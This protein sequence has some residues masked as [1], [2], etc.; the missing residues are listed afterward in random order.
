MPRIDPQKLLNCLSVLLAPN[1]GIRGPNDV[2][3]LTGLMAKFSKKLVS[4]CIYIQILKCTETDLL[5]QFMSAGGWSLTHMWL[6]D[7]ILSKNWPLVQEILE[8]L[9]L[10]PVDVQRLKS[11]TAPKLVK[12]L[13]KEGGVEAV[14][15]LATKLVEQ[16][17][18]IVKGEPMTVESTAV[19][20]GNAPAIANAGPKPTDTEDTAAKAAPTDGGT[21]SDKPTNKVDDVDNKDKLDAKSASTNVVFLDAVP[22]DEQETNDD[23]VSDPLALPSDVEDGGTVAGSGS[24]TKSKPNNEGL[25]FKITVKD[26]K[27][28][29]AKVESSPRKAAPPAITSPSANK[30]AKVID[31]DTIDS[32]KVKDLPSNSSSSSGKEEKSDKSEKDI[33]K[34]RGSRDSSKSKSRDKDRERDKNRDRE[35]IK[36]RKGSDSSRSSDIKSSSSSSKHHSSSSSSHRSSSSHKSSSRSSR[37]HKDSKDRERDKDK[38]KSSSSSTKSSS[39]SSSRDKSSSSRDKDRDKDKDNVVTEPKISQADK[40]K[41][42]LSKVMSQSISKLGKIPKKIH[43]AESDSSKTSAESSSSKKPSISIEVRKDA[44]NRPKTV[45]TFNSQFRSHGLAEEAPPPPSRRGLKKPSSTSAPGTAIPTTVGS[46]RLSVSPTHSSEAEKRP[47]LDTSLTEKPGA[48]KLISPKPKRTYTLTYILLIL[49]C[50]I[51]PGHVLSLSKTWHEISLGIVKN[52]LFFIIFISFSTTT[53]LNKHYFSGLI[54]I[55]HFHYPFPI[56][57]V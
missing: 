37:D 4:K 34:D 30:L 43:S 13:S 10:C 31:E 14:R 29:L 26:G 6:T 32:V 53:H 44:E 9:L 40:D 24:P 33:E 21:S 7:G 17:L 22:T 23:N 41:D 51:F 3:R 49:F 57:A 1:G 2:K 39:T 50:R 12:Q 15:I 48:I 8:L 36:E 38:H 52:S 25:V 55:N 47:K 46:K 11:N 28:M 45:K 27:Q 19:T 20:S 18:K 5:G 42:T 35:R 56:Q 54:L 16:W